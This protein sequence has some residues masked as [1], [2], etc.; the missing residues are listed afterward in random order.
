M[1]A[2]LAT[3]SPLATM[4]ALGGTVLWAALAGVLMVGRRI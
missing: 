4:G 1:L 3:G 2:G